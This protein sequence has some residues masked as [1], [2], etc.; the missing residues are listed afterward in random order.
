MTV[1]HTLRKCPAVNRSG[2]IG[3]IAFQIRSVAYSI[4]SQYVETDAGRS[5]VKI[6]PSGQITSN[7]R[8]QPSLAGRPGL[9]SALK[10]ERDAACS[11]VRPVLTGPGT[12]EGLPVKS[13][14]ILSAVTVT[15]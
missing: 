6:V 5:A 15:L 2:K 3:A 4:V 7:G 1:P 8:K 12:C 11:P 9:V 14:V 10:T 13:Q